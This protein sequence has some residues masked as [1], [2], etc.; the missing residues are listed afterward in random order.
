MRSA[1]APSP[2]SAASVSWNTSKRALSATRSSS[3]CGIQRLVAVQQRELVDFL[4]RGEQIA[5]DAFD[6]R[7]DRVAIGLAGRGC[8]MRCAIQSG[9]SFGFSG[10]TGTNSPL[11]STAVDPRAFVLP[12]SIA[13][14]VI[15]RTVSGGGFSQYSIDRRRAFLAGP[16]GRQAQVD[17]R[18]DGEQRHRRRAIAQRRSSRI[19]LRH[20]ALRVRCSPV[21]ARVHAARRRLRAAADVPRR[22][23][24]RP[25]CS[26]VPA[27]C[28]CNWASVSGMGIRPR[29]S[30]HHDQCAAPSALDLR[31]T[32]LDLAQHDLRHV[33]FH[34]LLDHRPARR[35]CRSPGSGRT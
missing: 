35:R 16:A 22:R 5:F 21:R 30:V 14:S 13:C 31:S 27:R 24:D 6:Q 2:A 23:A 25:A 4:R 1:R 10:H 3:V 7:L 18:R 8:A 19:S 33:A 32:A 15:S 34:F 29:Q 20:R 28:L 17:Q 26:S 9:N 11:F 12:C